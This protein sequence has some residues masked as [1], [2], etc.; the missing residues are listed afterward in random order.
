MHNIWWENGETGLNS[1]NDKSDDVENGDADAGE[2][3]CQCAYCFSS[4]FFSSN[5]FSRPVC[6]L[7]RLAI[8]LISSPPSLLIP[9]ALI[10]DENDVIIDCE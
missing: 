7:C 5:F 6:I 1:L 10:D 4:S 8:Q 3:M 9:I 2:K